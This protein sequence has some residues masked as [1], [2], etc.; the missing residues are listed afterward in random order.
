MRGRRGAPRQEA[1]LFR[2]QYPSAFDQA[3]QHEREK[4]GRPADP[5]GGKHRRWNENVRCALDSRRAH[6]QRVLQDAN[7]SHAEDC[8]EPA[9]EALSDQEISINA[10]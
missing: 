5:S 2:S 7:V 4:A 8:P 9:T 6:L 10:R 1:R 3:L